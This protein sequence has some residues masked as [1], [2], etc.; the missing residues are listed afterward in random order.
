MGIGNCENLISLLSTLPECQF[1]F[2]LYAC[3]RRLKEK[4]KAQQ[5]ENVK[6]KEK[7]KEE[8]KQKAL[9][10]IKKKKELTEN[11]R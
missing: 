6:R 4:R 2:K 11:Q 7:E 9:E 8:L 3:F 5:A 1:F 10:G